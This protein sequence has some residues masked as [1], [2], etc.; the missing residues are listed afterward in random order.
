MGTSGFG[1]LLM[2]ALVLQIVCRETGS[3][4]VTPTTSLDELGLDSLEFIDLLVTVSTE[5]GVEIPQANYA[6]INTVN[7]LIW[8]V[9]H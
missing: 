3:N 6:T 8:A 1:Y 5:T 7:D 4:D 2:K 9:S